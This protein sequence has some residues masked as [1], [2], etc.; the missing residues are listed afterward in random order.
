MFGVLRYLG[1]MVLRAAVSLAVFSLGQEKTCVQLEKQLEKTCGAEALAGLARR[2]P[3]S[4][5]ILQVMP[6]LA[7]WGPPGASSIEPA[8]LGKV[9]EALVAMHFLQQPSGFAAAAH[10]WR[11]TASNDSARRHQEQRAPNGQTRGNAGG[12]DII[13]GHYASRGRLPPS[14]RSRRCAM[15]ICRARF[16]VCVTSG[17]AIREMKRMVTG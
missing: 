8:E 7:S 3:V 14:L 11:R 10:F 2:L 4:S 1:S 6:D 5:E 16:S 13:F 12:I 15:T 17:S 9:F